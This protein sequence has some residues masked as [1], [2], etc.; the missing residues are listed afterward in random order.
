MA[1]ITKVTEEHIGKIKK[2]D[3]ID[4]LSYIIA[5]I[6][7]YETDKGVK[8]A[9]FYE[10]GGTKEVIANDDGST[11]KKWKDKE[12]RI[13]YNHLSELKKRIDA[14]DSKNTW[15]G[16][17]VQGSFDNGIDKIAITTPIYENKHV[18]SDYKKLIEF[19]SNA[20]DDDYVKLL[21]I[22]KRY[23]RILDMSSAESED[24]KHLILTIDE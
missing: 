11:I 22:S 5:Y 8:C 18:I 17:I 9:I 15:L 10:R 4:V 6:G 19:D 21:D 23:T 3:I 24:P 1:N 7:D 20:S 2:D 14:Y 13:P 16:K 12:I